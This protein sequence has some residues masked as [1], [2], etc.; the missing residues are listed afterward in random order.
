[1]QMLDGP[2]KCRKNN[3][4]VKFQPG[5]KKQQCEAP[6]PQPSF[7]PK[8]ANPEIISL[9]LMLTFSSHLL[10]MRSGKRSDIPGLVLRDLLQ[11]KSELKL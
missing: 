1:M 4:D 7:L 11:E 6:P 5:G 2:I 10:S 8:E 9:K 3:K